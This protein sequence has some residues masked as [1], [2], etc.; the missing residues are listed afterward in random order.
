[1]SGVYYYQYDGQTGSLSRRLRGDLLDAEAYTAPAL[2][3]MLRRWGYDPAPYLAESRL[4]AALNQY[5]L[6]TGCRGDMPFGQRRA[7]FARILADPAARDAL[8]S[9]LRQ[10]ARPLLAVPYRIGVA[11]NAPGWLAA[12]TLFKQRFL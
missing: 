11:L 10:D 7:L 6:L 2:E 12:Y 1:M 5:G 9:R 4:R 8:R 3:A